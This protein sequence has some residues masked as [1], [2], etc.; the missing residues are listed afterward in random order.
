MGLPD[1]KWTESLFIY[2]SEGLIILHLL[3][4]LF[5]ALHFVPLMLTVNL[6]CALSCTMAYLQLKKEQIRSCILILYIT[7]MIQ[8]IISAVCVGFSAGF[9]LPLAGLTAMVFLGEYL[10]RSMK[11]PYIPAL[12]L[13]LIN[14]VVYLAAF[15]PSRSRFYGAFRFLLFS[16]GECIRSYSCL[17]SPNTALPTKPRPTS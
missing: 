1:R 7:E 15:L 13:G 2:T 4:T 16:S 11:L 14:L 8:L 17:P 6:V 3:L 9:Q 5:Y 10:G 12:P